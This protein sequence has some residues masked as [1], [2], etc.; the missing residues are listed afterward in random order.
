MNTTMNRDLK[1]DFHTE[2]INLGAADNLSDNQSSQMQESPSKK[3]A[4]NYLNKNLD[5]FLII[6][7]L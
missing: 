5:K 3:E 2:N 1:F 7:K 6:S 4:E